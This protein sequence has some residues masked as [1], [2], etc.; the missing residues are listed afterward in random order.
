[1]NNRHPQRHRRLPGHRVP[2]AEGGVMTE[3]PKEQ[4]K[5]EIEDLDEPLVGRYEK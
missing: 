2:H 4:I 1:M 5:R 3:T